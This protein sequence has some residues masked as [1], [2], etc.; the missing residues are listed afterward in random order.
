MDLKVTIVGETG[1]GKTSLAMSFATNNFDAQQKSNS[2]AAFWKKSIDVNDTTVKFQIWDTAGQELYR[3]MAPMYMK[4]AEA[5]FIV[6]DV[7]RPQTLA[8]VAFWHDQIK[9][10]CAQSV[11]VY[12]IGNKIDQQRNVTENEAFIVAKQFGMK[13]FETSALKGTGVNSAFQKIAEWKSQQTISYTT[14][15]VIEDEVEKKKCCC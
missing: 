12:L 5:I 4:S 15:R 2:V 11:E 14:E 6:I 8:Q 1:V 7:T 9:L 10:N 3:S 13:Y